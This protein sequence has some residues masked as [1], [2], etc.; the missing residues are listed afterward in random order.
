MVDDLTNRGARDRARVNIHEEH[1]VRYWSEK[2]CV[3]KEQLSAAVAR[4]GV[5]ADAVA[6]EL[7]KAPPTAG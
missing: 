2:W 3:T 1:E 4:V 6:Q 7:G 5:S